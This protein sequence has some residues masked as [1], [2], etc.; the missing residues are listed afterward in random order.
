MKISETICFDSHQTQM[1]LPFRISA[2]APFY[3]GSGARCILFLIVEVT[4][5]IIVGSRLEDLVGGY[6]TSVHFFDT[7]GTGG[8]PPVGGS[9]APTATSVRV[10][11][12]LGIRQLWPGLLAL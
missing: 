8:L 10:P 1:I 7:S 6:D 12:P 2:A 11:P 4:R 5:S 9:G 3:S